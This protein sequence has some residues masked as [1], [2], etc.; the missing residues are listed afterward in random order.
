[1]LTAVLSCLNSGMYTASRM[2]FVL[3]G[4]REAPLQLVHVTK[5]GVPAV[6]ILASSVIG[7]LCV[8]AAA[9]SP[10]TVFAFLLNSSGAII[11]FIYCLIGIS[12]IVLRYRTGSAGLRVK[13]WLFP[14]LSIITVAGI[15]AIL[16]QM[17]IVEESRSQL[18]LSLLSWAIVIVFY[19][20][21][22]WFI[23]RRPIVEGAIATTKPHRVLVMANETAN[24]AE[25]L[26]ELRRI[27]ADSATSYYV[28]VPASP[29]ETGVTATHGPLDVMEAT[30]EAAKARLDYTLSTLRSEN[31]EADGAL[32]DYRPMRALA[33]AV[34]TFHP[35]QIVIAT[36][37]L[38]S[39]VWHRFEVVDRARAEYSN[40]PVTH[41]VATPVAAEPAV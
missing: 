6:A 5:R 21:N 28:V 12:Q 41:V 10:D 11:L 25:L 13:M 29:I 26:D 17:G 14:V 4:R 1:V 33:D 20:A 19:F 16:A 18:I 34:D 35:D 30:H 36:L 40:L 9:V 22:K 3:A 15:V 8:I 7:F 23:G 38:E 37:P 31:L 2:L 39:S 24:S 27:G 32:G